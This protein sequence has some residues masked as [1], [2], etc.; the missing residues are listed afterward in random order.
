MADK[1][2]LNRFRK[3]LAV[4]FGTDSPSQL[5]YSEDLSDHGIFIKT[6]KICALG[7]ILQIE[8]T[9]PEEE[10]VF[11]E[12]MVRWSKKFPPEMIHKVQKGGIGIK[13]TKFIAGQAAYHQLV[14]DMHAKLQ[15]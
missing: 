11:F 13:I 9:L 7:T 10:Y 14:A 8:L 6:S 2:N 1:R 15:D 5:A 12:G 3:R 4:R